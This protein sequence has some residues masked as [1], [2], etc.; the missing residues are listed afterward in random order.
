ML[1]LYPV[2]AEK[3]IT[4]GVIE[5]CRTMPYGRVHLTYRETAVGAN[6]TTMTE[7]HRGTLAEQFGIRFAMVLES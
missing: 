1:G 6:P 7:L 3:N 5:S 4:S 2:S